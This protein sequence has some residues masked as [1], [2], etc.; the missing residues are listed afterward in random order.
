MDETV[1]FKRHRIVWNEHIKVGEREYSL[2][3]ILNTLKPMLT[4]ERIH[5]L[6]EVS[7]SRSLNLVSVLENIYDRGNV[8]AVMRSF[9]AFG[10][11]QMHL[12]D[13]PGAKFKAANRVTKGAEKWLD[14]HS[15]S[16]PQ[17][18]VKELK[19]NGY[20]IWATDLNTQY[21][22]EDLNWSKPMAIVLGNE[23][24][25]VSEELKGMV[26]GT[27]RVP[28]LGFSQSFNISVAAALIFYHGHLQ[29]KGGG[30]VTEQQRQMILANYYL[31]CFDNPE[32][33][34]AL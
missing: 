31:R 9:E 22:I 32:K 28:M 3:H 13:A 29:L 16:S 5:R 20:Q 8:S 17:S 33:L 21:S 30:R 15:H 34:L 11:L 18:A 24:D 26:D 19:Q 1:G 25:G 12:I 4:D 7:A 23:K 14:T 27:F 10:F 6:D 2:E